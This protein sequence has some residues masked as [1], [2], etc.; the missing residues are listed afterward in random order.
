MT[1]V[2]KCLCGALQGP[3]RDACCYPWC[4]LCVWCLKR[5]PVVIISYG[6]AWSLTT[7][8]EV[9]SKYW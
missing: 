7:S 1:R 3:W 6:L 9:T 5:A 4:C 2:E 8:A